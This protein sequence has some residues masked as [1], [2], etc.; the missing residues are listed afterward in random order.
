[1]SVYYCSVCDEWFSE[2]TSYKKDLNK[3]NHDLPQELSDED[4][5]GCCSS[6]VS[7]NFLDQDEI[8]SMLNERGVKWKTC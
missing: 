2:D 3:D 8:I 6:D 5:C 4:Y 7:D 1:M